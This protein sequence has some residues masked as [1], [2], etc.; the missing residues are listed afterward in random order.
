MVGGA[1]GDVVALR[2]VE[3]DETKF[4]PFPVEPVIRL[5]CAEEILL[6]NPRPVV[7]AETLAGLVVDD[8]PRLCE[9]G[10]PWLIEGDR[11]WAVDSQFLGPVQDAL[12]AG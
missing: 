1:G 6:I 8:P 3:L 4:G 12:G 2:T 11:K 9:L 7:H 5:Q 10:V